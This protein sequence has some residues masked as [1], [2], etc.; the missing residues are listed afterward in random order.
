M[1]QDVWK[2]CSVSPI[3]GW[4]W[5]F[6]PYMG[7]FSSRKPFCDLFIYCPLIVALIVFCHTPIRKCLLMLFVSCREHSQ[8]RC[9]H[10]HRCCYWHYGSDHWHHCTHH[11]I[12]SW[13]SSLPLHQQA[14][15]QAWDILSPTAAGNSTTA[16]SW[17]RVWG[18]SWTERERA[19]G[20]A[21]SIELKACEVYVP[22]QHWLSLL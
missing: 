11:W 13:S 10:Q 18:G 19:Y 15:L 21:K 1:A 5:G 16:A 3:N 14:E 20:P 6:H 17:S 22:V 12:P 9:Y 2:Y 8:H 7:L 4:F